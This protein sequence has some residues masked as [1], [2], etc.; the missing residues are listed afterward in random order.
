MPFHVDDGSAFFQLACTVLLQANLSLYLQIEEP[1][2]MLGHYNRVEQLAHIIIH[3]QH[4]YP[5]TMALLDWS[6]TTTE[7]YDVLLND[8]NSFENT[9]MILVMTTL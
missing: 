8:W 2:R 6:N 7:P 4:V 9:L 3:L 5:D 1:P